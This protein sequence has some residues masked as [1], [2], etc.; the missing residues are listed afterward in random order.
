MFKICSEKIISNGICST[1]IFISNPNS[2]V[3]PN[4]CLND[5]NGFST[6]ASA[7]KQTLSSTGSLLWSRPFFG[8][9]AKSWDEANQFCT[10]LQD[11]GY[12]WR[13]PQ[14]AEI[15]AITTHPSKFKTNINEVIDKVW[16]SSTANTSA[17]T[18]TTL[19]GILNLEFKNTVNPFICVSNST[20]PTVTYTCSDSDN[21]KT[22]NQKGTVI[23]NRPNWT[24]DLTDSCVVRTSE[25]QYQPVK[26]CTGSNCQINEWSCYNTSSPT[27]EFINCN[28]CRD[29]GCLDYGPPPNTSSSTSSGSSS[30]SSSSSSGS[31]VNP[32]RLSSIGFANNDVE[33]WY[34]KNFANCATLKDY[35]GN[36]IN[37]TDFCTNT[38]AYFKVPS[39]R[40]SGL[41]AG[42]RVRLCD[43]NNSQNC[44]EFTTV[45]PHFEDIYH[46]CKTQ[47]TKFKTQDGGCTNLFNAHT[48]WSHLAQ[49][50]FND[51]KDFCNNLIIYVISSGAKYDD[52][53]MPT[54]DELLY[55]STSGG[56]KD[57]FNF[58]TNQLFWADENGIDNSGV[59]VNLS[60]ST[61]STTSNKDF[62]QNVTCTRSTSGCTNTCSVGKFNCC[63]GGIYTCPNN[64]P[65]ACSV[66]GRPGCII[67]A[68][69]DY[70]AGSCVAPISPTVASGCNCING[71]LTCS[72]DCNPTCNDSTFRPACMNNV[73]A[74]YSNYGYG[75]T[76]NTL[77]CGPVTPNT[78]DCMYTQCGTT[79]C[80]YG[81]C[82]NGSNIC[83]GSNE[84]SNSFVTQ[85]NCKLED[86]SFMAQNGGCQE[87]STAIVWSKK[88]IYLN[89]WINA[90]DYCENLIE[91][92]FADWTLPTISELSNIFA[93]NKAMNYLNLDLTYNYW[94]SSQSTSDSNSA[95][96]INLTTGIIANN[97]K[98][99]NN[100][101]VCVR[102]NKP[103]V[104]TVNLVVYSSSDLQGAIDCGNVNYQSSCSYLNLQSNTS[105][106]ILAKPYQT[107]VFKEWQYLSGY[108]QTNCIINNKNSSSTSLEVKK[109]CK[110]K[111]VFLKPAT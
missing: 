20:P 107:Y 3:L 85:S 63:N 97:S 108:D 34:E 12:T 21:G 54:K 26:L 82:S 102:N 103:V 43:N 101:V 96:V 27:F 9:Y 16:T 53:R 99:S 72:N 40:F 90:V 67:N 17:Y 64:G 61:V 38:G 78:S 93:N 57:H 88:D 66:D 56:A 39:S 80:R 111:A 104:S 73:S 109:D 14:P 31:S 68:L 4:K 91:A 23:T 15:S 22:Y 6:V 48:A 52:W 13:L 87:I 89:P 30:T 105:V 44:T 110:I 5:S 19:G 65:Q 7:C 46:A 62:I 25:F 95:Q 59:L 58:N 84:C 8:S 33:I 60:D 36:V 18:S 32:F 29:G 77:I 10:Q 76:S 24:G 81:C 79:C 94:S 49:R 45:R 83:L 70:N 74:C 98:Q 28:N 75:S 1:P 92:G 11:G 47:D 69:V 2:L 100:A 55:I 86:A 35:Y 42:M 37:N 106:N 51:A 71:S 41:A 50:A